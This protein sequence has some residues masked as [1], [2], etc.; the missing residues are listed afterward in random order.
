MVFGCA[1]YVVEIEHRGVDILGGVAIPERCLAT[2]ARPDGLQV[3]LKGL[4]VERFVVEFGNG[5]FAGTSGSNEAECNCRKQISFHGNA[6]LSYKDSTNPQRLQ[7]W[8]RS[9]SL[10]KMNTQLMAATMPAICQ[11]DGIASN[12]ATAISTM[13]SRQ[14]ITGEQASA[15]GAMTMALP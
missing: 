5:F 15:S 6:G 14:Q 10:L 3:F 1:L 9:Y 8:R 4:C 2:Y 12:P 7:A 13:D 11:M